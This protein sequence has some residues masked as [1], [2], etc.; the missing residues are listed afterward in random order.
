MKIEIETMWKSLRNLK[1]VM[2]EINFEQDLSSRTVRYPSGGV[3][4]IAEYS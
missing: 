1:S 4:S 2:T 3:N